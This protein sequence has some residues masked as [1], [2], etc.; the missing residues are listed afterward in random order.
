L[1]LTCERCETRFRL[2]E[3]RLPAGGARV[4]CSRCKHAFFVNP[5]GA[6]APAAVHELAEAALTQSRPPA[7]AP[8]WDLEEDPNA[9]TAQSV[10]NAITSLA[11]EPLAGDFE[12]ESD[13]RFE[14]EMQ[15]GDSGA[16]LDLPNGEA[17]APPNADPNDSSFAELGDPESW[18]LLSN[19]AAPEPV[20]PRPSLPEPATSAAPKPAARVAAKTPAP[21]QRERVQT[22]EVATPA[23]EAPAILLEPEIS[24]A[25]RTG[26]WIGVAVLVAVASWTSLAPLA[27]AA[28]Q[29]AVVSL[30]ELELDSLQLRQVENAW[31][32]PIWVVSGEL[33]NPSDAPHAVGKAVAI[34]LRD[35]SGDRIGGAAAVAQPSLSAERLRED[36]PATWDEVGERAATELASQTLAPGA[37]IPVDAVF[38]TPALR[39]ARFA[40]ET[41]APRPPP[42]AP[43][44][45]PAPIAVDPAASP[46]PIAPLAN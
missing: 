46:E 31:A 4:R 16:S 17:P 35:G 6:P 24:P 9:R 21:E 12:E 5:A 36:D 28:P 14:D 33:H 25:L 10:T 44:A 37:R 42:P 19:T 22:L 29:R 43:V 34:E 45:V 1:I 27:P 20:V 11:A 8:S 38:A 15:L 7:P 3:S 13:W 23:D 2:D 32:G 39:A 40:V 41:R 26:A 18:D 30:G